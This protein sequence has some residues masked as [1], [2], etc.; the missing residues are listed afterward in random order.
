MEYEAPLMP[1]GCIL[2]CGVGFG[3]RLYFRAGGCQGLSAGYPPKRGA[4]FYSQLPWVLIS[5]Q[6]L[7]LAIPL[8]ADITALVFHKAGF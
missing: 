2:L 1:C 6:L 7:L 5:A 8:T 3:L 4:P